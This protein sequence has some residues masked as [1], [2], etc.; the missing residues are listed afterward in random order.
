MSL[1]PLTPAFKFQLMN[2]MA[3][4]TDDDYNDYSLKLKNAVGKNYLSLE[5]QDNTIELSLPPHLGENRV[6]VTAV[7]NLFKPSSRHFLALPGL[8]TV[9]EV[10]LVTQLKPGEMVAVLTW[11]QGTYLNAQGYKMHNL[12][13][14]VE[15]QPRDDVL[16]TV[17]HATRDCNG[18]SLT[19]DSELSDGKVSQSQAVKLTKLGEI[20]YLIYISLNNFDK[21]TT[22]IHHTRDLMA[23]LKIYTH[24]QNEAA[25]SVDMPFVDNTET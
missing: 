15:F 5:N 12:D 21:S 10:P 13:L 8:E 7:D 24:G 11:I 17:D 23:N 1:L 16:C 2:V 6:E 20:P 19:M 25:F 18:V 4:D 9:V 14:H 22:A 3:D